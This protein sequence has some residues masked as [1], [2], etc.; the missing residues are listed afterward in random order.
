MW[1]QNANELLYND[2]GQSEELT[3]GVLNVAQ[4]R[5]LHTEREQ[6]SITPHNHTSL[7]HLLAQQDEEVLLQMH[8]TSLP[9]DA[10]VA[11]VGVIPT[12]RVKSVGNKLI[13]LPSWLPSED[14]FSP[15]NETLKLFAKSFLA[16]EHIMG[17]TNFR[18]CVWRKYACQ[19]C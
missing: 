9:G 12:P 18:I 13:L 6:D 7:C 8:A 10:P 15:E 19:R 11:D 3:L 1:N 17:R 4:V 16:F 2:C 5:Q 14:T